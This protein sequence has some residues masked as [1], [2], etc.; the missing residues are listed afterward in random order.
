MFSSIFLKRTNRRKSSKQKVATSDPNTSNAILALLEELYP[1][2]H[3][4]MRLDLDEDPVIFG[5]VPFFELVL[6]YFFLSVLYY[7]I[8]CCESG[9][10]VFYYT[11]EAEFKEARR[12]RLLFNRLMR[13]VENDY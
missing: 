1:E 13:Y 8:D 5:S 4:V 10:G 6:P 3:F 2:E 7:R 12:L 11:S 9:H